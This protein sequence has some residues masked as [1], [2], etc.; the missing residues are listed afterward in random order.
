VREIENIL[1]FFVH[2]QQEKKK[3]KEAAMRG[4]N[5]FSMFFL[6]A[7]KL[8]FDS[9]LILNWKEDAFGLLCSVTIEPEYCYTH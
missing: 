2:P 6:F 9:F 7:I 8:F 1:H 5:L 4:E 3:W